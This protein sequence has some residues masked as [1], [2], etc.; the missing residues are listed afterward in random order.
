MK[1]VFFGFGMLELGGGFEN[2]LIDTTTDLKEL[3]PASEFSIIT[4]SPRLT[5]KYY[6]IITHIALRPESSKTLYRETSSSIRK[7]LGKVTYTTFDS[8][9]ELKDIISK[10]DVVYTK[11]ELIELGLL[12]FIRASKFTPI[13]IGIS[14]PI[15]YPITPT[16][17]S[18][19]H[20]ILYKSRFY[21]SLLKI[22]AIIKTLNR[23]DEKYIK[24]K[25]G[26]NNVGVLHHGFNVPKIKPT[27][28][29]NGQ[30]NVLFAGRLTEQKGL[31]ILLGAIK[32][33]NLDADANGIKF[34][35]AGTG[36]KAETEI[37]KKLSRLH[38]NVYYLGHVP[39]ARMKMLYKWADITIM[40]SK[41]ETLNKIAVETGIYGN[42]AISSDIPG[43]REVI[44]NNKSG[45]LIPP[46]PESFYDKIIYLK[47]LKDNDPKSFK[48][49]GKNAQ[50]KIDKEFNEIY[51]TESLFNILKFLMVDRT[52]V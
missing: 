15:Q 17:G 1:A 12:K 52:L 31:D 47:K 21:G 22:G 3:H 25:F 35:I 6:K 20:N 37:V 50:K 2:F 27:Y 43:P 29:R 19:L 51:L 46:T 23:D 36:N 5:E 26:L 33:I 32:L 42:I 14:T 11:N 4:S 7:R 41:Y 38:T 18:K 45:Y 16:F 44:D 30:L 8:I 49:I 9:A 48:A 34:R 10:A 40:P 13:M 28:S 24:I 39:Q